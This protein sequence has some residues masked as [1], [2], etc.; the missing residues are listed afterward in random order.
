MVG[1]QWGQNRLFL[2]GF[3]DT[4]D[5]KACNCLH[6]GSM[7]HR[8]WSCRTLDPM[9][10]QGISSE[11]VKEAQETLQTEPQHPLWNRCL[12]PLSSLPALPALGG[13][14]FHWYRNDGGGVFTGMCYSDGAMRARWWWQESQR[15]GWG[16]ISLAGGGIRCS[17]GI[18]GLLPGPDQCVPP[19]GVACSL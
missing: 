9:R 17:V 2:A 13:D 4:R 16:A 7:S 18:Y 14:T 15:A 8:T 6:R 5:C 11:L 10:E 19:G 3:V 12:I 1:S